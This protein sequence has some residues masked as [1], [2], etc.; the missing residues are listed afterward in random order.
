MKDPYPMFTQMR[1]FAEYV[2]EHADRLKTAADA[3]E[4]VNEWVKPATPS[5]TEDQIRII[6]DTFVEANREMRAAHDTYT[7]NQMKESK[8][9]C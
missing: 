4:K 1:K 3:L 9:P 8:I 5:P 7:R 6:G 2:P